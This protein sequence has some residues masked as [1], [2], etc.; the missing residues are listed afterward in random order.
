M[1]LDLGSVAAQMAWLALPVIFS[2][3]FHMFVVKQRWL[4]RLARP[5]DRGACF[6]GRRIFGDNKTWRGVVVMIGAGAIAGAVQGFFGGSALSD[7]SALGAVWLV[8]TGPPGDAVPLGYALQYGAA[9]ALFGL[10]YALGELP[11]SFLKRQIDIAPG[12]AGAGLLGAFF[13]LLDQADSVA[14]C[15]LVGWMVFPLSGALV[16]MSI[17][18][19]TVLHLLLNAALHRGGVRK[20]L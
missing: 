19:M 9:H 12:K 7:V 10:G 4:P 6:R 11:N 5:I 20:N 1:N 14:A 3:V 17:A 15:L 2:G 8:D 16:L 18:S 13:L